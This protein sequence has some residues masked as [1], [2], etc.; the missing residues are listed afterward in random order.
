MALEFS[1]FLPQMRLTM[2]QLVERARAAEAAG[3]VGMTGMDHLTPRSP[4]NSRCSRRCSPT[5]GWPRTPNGCASAPWCCATRSVTL[6]CWRGKPSPST[7][8]RT[9]AS[10]SA[11]AG[12]RPRTSSRCSASARPWRPSGSAGCA[13]R[14][15]SSPRSGRAR[16]VDYEGEHFTLQGAHQEPRPLGHIP[17][18]IGGAGN[19]TMQLVA[20][21]A[22]WW[23]VHT[24]ILDKLE[25]LDD[26]RARAGRPAPLAALR[27]APSTPATTARR[28]PHS[29]NGASV[30]AWWSAPAP[31]S[32]T[33]SAALAERGFE[34][35]Y[36]WFCDFA[37]PHTLTAFGNEVIT[38]FG[39]NR[40]GASGGTDAVGS[41][42]ATWPKTASL[43]QQRPAS[44]NRIRRPSC[45]ITG[46]ARL[47]QPPRGEAQSVSGLVPIST[48]SSVPVPN[49]RDRGPP[50]EAI[51][52]GAAASARSETPPCEADRLLASG[53]FSATGA[54]PESG[55][56]GRGGAQ[57]SVDQRVDAEAAGA[58]ERDDEREHAEGEV[59]LVALRCRRSR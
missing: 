50:P 27:R 49:S 28:S 5:P 14:S 15:R 16:R 23:N 30:R 48:S 29:R 13:R 43:S 17:I 4:R 11:S 32:S 12:A 47:V 51:A 19:Q 40:N 33:T 31:S 53:R 42:A 25:Q 26:L 20:K 38:A 54:L 37:Q 46:R 44:T 18:V 6:R 7:T 59:Q 55:R 21:H 9:A 2:P 56:C 24:G 41:R 52:A 36:A 35:V 39:V 57:P 10:T 8:R 58:E 1:L 34:R 3:F 22:D 45:A